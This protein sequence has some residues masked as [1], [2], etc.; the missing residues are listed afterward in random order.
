MT[1]SP[2]DDILFDV[3]AGVGRVVLNRPKALNALT[4]EMCVRFRQKL[5]DWAAD[6]AV[7]A[8]VIQGA[9]DKAFCAGGDIRKLYDEG[10]AGGDYP[11]AF[12]SDEYR[13]NAAV[14]HFP[15]PYVAVL[16]GIVMGGGVGVSAHGSHRVVSD[17]VMFAMPETG[18]GLFPDVGGSYFLPRCPGQIG[19]YLGLTGARLKAADLRYAGLAEA[20]VPAAR[21]DEFVTALSEAGRDVE[22]VVAAFATDAGPAPLAEH[23]DAIDRHFGHGS[24]EAIVD[25]LQNDPS[26]WAAKTARTIAGK[27]PTSLKVT[28]RQLR[29]GAAKDFDDCMRMEWRMV[30]RIIAG[31][32]FYEGTRAVVID[33]DQA[34]DWRPARLEDVTAADVVAYF[35]PLPDGDLDLDGET[36]HHNQRQT[37]RT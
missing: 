2:T 3:T 22:S 34:P 6:D 24:V 29:E 9:G 37:R 13:L 23:R 18:I 10:R 1:E 30:N 16:N 7:R 36:E 17:N 11:F 31:H 26:D 32:D 5:V 20:Y 14:Y 12:Y 28:F 8:L 4:H 21:L 33:K 35:A 25:S 15:K 19:L 27:S